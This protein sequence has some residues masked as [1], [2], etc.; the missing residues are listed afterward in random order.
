MKTIR[1]I[2]SVL[3]RGHVAINCVRWETENGEAGIC[4][5]TRVS[6]QTSLRYHEVN[7]V[8]GTWYRVQ[9]GENP[10]AVP[11]IPSPVIVHNLEGAWEVI[12]RVYRPLTLPERLRVMQVVGMPAPGNENGVDVDIELPSWGGQR[13]CELTIQFLGGACYGWVQ[14]LETDEGLTD[15]WRIAAGQG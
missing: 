11:V 12:A 13:Y 6:W 1:D 14:E 15:V 2:L 10:V 9:D 4:S 5:P 7:L 3:V 8:T